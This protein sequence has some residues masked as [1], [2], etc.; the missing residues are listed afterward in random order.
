M[1]GRAKTKIPPPHPPSPLLTPHP[2]SVPIVAITGG[3]PCGIGPEI[4]LKALAAARLPGPPLATAGAGGRHTALVI[5]GD[6]AVFARAAKGL[7]CPLPRWAV[8][9]PGEDWRPQEQPLVFVDCRRRVRFLPGRPTAAAGAAA[10]AYLDHAIALWRERRIHALVTAPVTKWAIERS[11]GRFEGQTEYLAAAMGERDVVM[12]FV[13]DRLRVAL[14]TRHLPLT[15][16]AGAVTRRGLRTALRLTHRA[17][18]VHFQREHP[19]LAVC[20]LN[21]H[22]GEAGLFGTEERRLLL[23][24]LRDLRRQGVRCDGPFAADGFFAR[25]ADGAGPRYDAVLCWYHDQGLIPFKMVARDRGCQLSVGLPLVRTSPDHGSALD[26][27]GRG[28]AD[29]GSMRYALKLAIKLA[30]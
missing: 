17:L 2:P 7:R 1:K 26:I 16:V 28:I 21:P 27:A 13:S 3:D 9:R 6:H 8:V 30:R 14:L 18:M 10:L 4:V 15:K 29:A 22:A 19:R 5:I 23:P 11:Y 12:M 20:G 25:L 24:V